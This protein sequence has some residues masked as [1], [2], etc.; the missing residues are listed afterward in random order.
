MADEPSA[1]DP[2]AS[3]PSASDPSASGPSA[4][5]PSA[6][7][8]DTAFEARKLLRAARSGTLATV[9][10]GGQPFA[11][12]VTHA[13]APDLSV[14]LLLSNLSEH[15]RHLRAE[16]R[17]SILLC[18]QA[19]G[20][21]PQTA[22]RLTVTGIAKVADD[23]ALKARFLA[24][25]PYAALYANF[26]DFHLWQVRPMGA[27]FVGGF[28]QAVRLRQAELAPDSAAVAAI[29]AAEA[30]IIGHC[31]SDHLDALA[32]IAGDAGD[33]CMAA[34]DVDGTDLVAGE[35]VL[36]VPWSVSVADSGGVRTELVRMA[37]EARAQ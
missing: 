16:P 14:L 12:L 15:T 24:V 20:A 9:A 18:G 4:S 6:S 23:A 30:G 27:L 1:S 28:A 11:S 8:G 21:N 17:C 35:R 19:E 31:N 13:C 2:S 5:G 29:A 36:R 22:P 26:G 34:V 10:D 25:H 7:L 37:R 3:G 33:W 32:A